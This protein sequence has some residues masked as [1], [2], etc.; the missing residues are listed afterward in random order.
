MMEVKSIIRGKYGKTKKKQFN[1]PS[2]VCYTVYHN[3]RHYYGEH[4]KTGF[5]P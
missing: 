1:N 4:Y 5:M 3:N 2:P